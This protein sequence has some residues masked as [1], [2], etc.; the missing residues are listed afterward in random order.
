MRGACL[1]KMRCL[2]TENDGCGQ[3]RLAIYR[4]ELLDAVLGGHA[5]SLIRIF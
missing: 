1:E 3:R 2:E 5:R 4:F